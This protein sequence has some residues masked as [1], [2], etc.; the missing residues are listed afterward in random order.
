MAS[1]LCTIMASDPSIE[2][3]FNMLSEGIGLGIT[4]GLGRG[5]TGG[6]RNMTGA[7]ERS[8]H[9][10]NCAEGARGSTSGGGMQAGVIIS[11]SG[12]SRFTSG[13]NVVKTSGAVS[14]SSLRPALEA[15]E[16]ES[17]WETESAASHGWDELERSCLVM[18]SNNVQ[19]DG[20]N[21]TNMLEEGVAPADSDSEG[22]SNE[23]RSSDE[24]DS[25]NAEWRRDDVDDRG[26]AARTIAAPSTTGDNSSFRRAASADSADSGLRRTLL[27]RPPS[28]N[29]PTRGEGA[30]CTPHFPAAPKP[31]SR[32]SRTFS[33]RQRADAATTP[34]PLSQS[35]GSSPLLLG[36]VKESHSDCFPGDSPHSAPLR[37]G[38]GSTN[39]LNSS[40]GSL[41]LSSSYGSSFGGSS[42]GGSSFGGSSFG[43]SSNDVSSGGSSSTGVGSC[44]L[45]PSPHHVLLWQSSAGESWSWPM[46]STRSGDMSP[47]AS[48]MSPRVS[49]MPPM[50]RE[51]IS[52]SGA[53]TTP[54][55][56][57]SSGATGGAGEGRSGQAAQNKEPT[58]AAVAA[59]A[60]SCKPNGVRVMV[61][62]GA[63]PAAIEAYFKMK[64]Q[65]GR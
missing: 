39:S 2:Q 52:A 24:S 9:S 44:D 22:G 15:V 28:A 18:D 4:S 61:K 45:K 36:N 23:D 46:A 62:A 30:E 41:E 14:M 34:I 7:A 11:S 12:N 43:G 49:H 47:R 3:R 25:A 51:G 55:R 35:V 53:S 5:N 33:P 26:G 16:E 65:R 57:T 48:H 60:D 19:I 6:G 13:V 42:F 59:A 40:S 63:N 17:G 38:F 58:A 64:A 21:L 20:I 31:A 54:L 10:D 29:S 50:P 8:Y 56:P 37:H 27:H 1:K 32:L